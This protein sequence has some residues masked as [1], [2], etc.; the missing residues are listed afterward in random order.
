MMFKA[1]LMSLWIIGTVTVFAAG[2]TSAFDGSIVTLAVEDG[3]CPYPTTEIKR[4]A[5]SMV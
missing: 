2:F 4:I 3:F 1:S 5:I